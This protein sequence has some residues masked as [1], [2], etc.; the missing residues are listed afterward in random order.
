MSIDLYKL[1]FDSIGFLAL[2][3]ASAIYL[4]ST[5]RKVNDGAATELIANLTKLRETDKEEFNNRLK[6]LEAQHLEDA[7]ALANMQGQI[8]TYKDIPLEKLADTMTSMAVDIRSNAQ[9]NAAIL[10]TLQRSAVI[11]ATDRDVAIGTVGSVAK[12]NITEQTVE[13]QTVKGVV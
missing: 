10:E 2:I 7:K 9:S 13:H 11:A 1:G 8:A 12:Q 3:A 5:T 6:I 4:K